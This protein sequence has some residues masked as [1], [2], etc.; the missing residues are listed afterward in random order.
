MNQGTLHQIRETV[1]IPDGE[2]NEEDDDNIAEEPPVPFHSEAY[3]SLS[4]SI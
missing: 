2:D 1:T 4:T 3:T